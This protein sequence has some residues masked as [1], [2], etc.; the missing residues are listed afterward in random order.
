MWQALKSAFKPTVKSFSWNLLIG[1]AVGVGVWT[2]LSYLPTEQLTGF[3][4]SSQ[5]N[6]LYE[7]PLYTTA[8][9]SLVQAFAAGFTTLY[10][11]TTKTLNAIKNHTIDRVMSPD[12]PDL[13]S[14][15]VAQQVGMMSAALAV[16]TPAIV[17]ADG[18]SRPKKPFTEQYATLQRAG[19]THTD[20]LAMQRLMAEQQAMAGAQ[21]AQ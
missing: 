15:D 18:Q 1:A 14:V 11:E 12:L 13:P 9:F 5:G 7:H 8:F 20:A 6:P 17:G 10:T 4:F 21:H 3:D 2:C 19:L 16:N